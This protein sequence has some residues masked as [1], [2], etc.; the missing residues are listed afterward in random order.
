MLRAPTGAGC[1]LHVCVRPRRFAVASVGCDLPSA[2]TTWHLHDKYTRG[3]E[4]DVYDLEGEY[5]PTNE[6]TRYWAGGWACGS[7]C[8]A[9][10]ATA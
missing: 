3:S 7:V 5:D 6:L 9:V 1:L 10:R 2:V 8:A 4:N